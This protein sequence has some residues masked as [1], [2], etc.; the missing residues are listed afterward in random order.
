[1]NT[2][3]TFEKVQPEFGNNI[4]VKQHSELWPTYK[5]FW[6]FHPEVELVYVNKG[7]G[8]RHIGNHISYFNNSQLILIGPNLPHKGFT[9]R[10]ISQGKETLVQFKLE[11]LG[12]MFIKLPEI[13]RLLE[14]AKNGILYQNDTKKSVGPKIEKLAEFHGINR[15]V[16]LL[17]ILNDLAQAND[18]TILNADGFAFETKPQDSNRINIIYEYINLNFQ[19]NITLEEIADKVSM[20]VPAFCRYFK[21]TTGKTFTQLTNEYRVVHATKLLA[22]STMSISDIC[23]ECGFNNFS[24]FNKLFNSITGKSASKYRS[25]MKNLIQ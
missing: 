9:D 24:H 17:D 3:P 22:E 20:T 8:K 13:S 19:S 1:M 25:D 12:E 15:M 16:K 7:Q 11:V 5:A 6:H 10:L 18:Y 2:K 4:L 21:K 23:F 14:L